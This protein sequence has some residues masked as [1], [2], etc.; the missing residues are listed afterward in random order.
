MSEFKPR[1]FVA[2]IDETSLDDIGY[3]GQTFKVK[4]LTKGKIYK[5]RNPEFLSSKEKGVVIDDNGCWWHYNT[6]GFKKR[7][8]EVL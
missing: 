3:S 6:S 4:S 2:L 1:K 8:K 7:F 5:E